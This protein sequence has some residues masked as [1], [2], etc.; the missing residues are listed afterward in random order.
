MTLQPVAARISGGG[1][2]AGLD[3]LKSLFGPFHLIPLGWIQS[4]AMAMLCVV[5][6]TIWAG[7]GAGSILYLAAL[8]TVPDE[9]YEA[10][11]M[12]GARIWHKIFY[13]T[14]PQ[15]KYLIVIQFIAAVIAAF[16][17]GTD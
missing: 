17:G 7:A 14:L 15:L 11:E 6:P 13:I 2:S 3:S 12:D 10:A 4:P 16:Q 9:L 1:I 5:L 8:K